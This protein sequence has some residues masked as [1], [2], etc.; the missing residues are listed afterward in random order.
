MVLFHTV[1]DLDFG[2]PNNHYF[3]FVAYD[4]TPPDI[5][6]NAVQ[7]T[8]TDYAPEVSSCDV[9]HDLVTDAGFGSAI[10]QVTTS[11]EVVYGDMIGGETCTK[12]TRTDADGGFTDFKM[13][14]TDSDIRL[15]VNGTYDCSMA[16]LDVYIPS[17]NDFSGALANQVE[18][19][20]GDESGLGSG[21]PG[22]PGFW[23]DWV[24]ESQENIALDQWVTLT[25][26]FTGDLDDMNAASGVRDN[27]DL[28]VIR[29]G[30]SNHPESGVF[31]MKDFK[32]VQ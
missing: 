24:L 29:L 30:G 11:S 28:V 19:I 6:P 7:W 32:F 5:R 2:T 16:Q 12:F 22:S 4:G 23:T 3:T 17:S 1:N 10:D 27:M 25:F 13:W 31:Y 20:L 14:S 21:Q 26:D 18:I 9:T 15:D 8:P